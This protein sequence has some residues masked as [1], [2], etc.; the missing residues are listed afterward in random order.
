VIFWLF[1]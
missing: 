1:T